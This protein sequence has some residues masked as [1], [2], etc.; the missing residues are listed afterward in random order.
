MHIQ[1]T[2]VG[3]LQSEFERCRLHLKTVTVCYFKQTLR[4]CNYRNFNKAGEVDEV[5]EVLYEY[6]GI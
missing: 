3:L 2:S 6:C 1:Q 5:N 4:L